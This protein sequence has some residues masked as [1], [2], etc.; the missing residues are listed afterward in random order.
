MDWAAEGLLDGL[1]G[2][3]RAERVE[4]LDWLEELGFEPDQ[5]RQA[6]DEGLLLLLPADRVV[7]GPGR[8]TAEEVGERANVHPDF[9]RLLRRVNGLAV[10]EP[11][12]ASYS[13]VDVQ[14]ADVARQYTDLGIDAEQLLGSARAVGRALSGLAGSLRALV[15]ELVVKPG[16]SEVELAR[17]YAERVEVLLPLLGPML[18]SGLRA[19][20][21]QAVRTELI[22]AAERAAGSL[23]GER[24]VAVAFADIVGFTKL[25]EEVDTAQLERVAARLEARTRD[26]ISPPVSLVKTIGD[27]VLLVSPDAAALLAVC[28]Q[29]SEAAGERAEEAE[30][31]E[32][33][34]QLR[35]GM[36]Y[37]PA[38]SRGGDW[39]GRA[40][41]LASRVAAAARPGSVL[42]VQAARDAAGEDVAHFSSAGSKHFKGVQGA[43]RLHRAR[44]L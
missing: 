5:I 39:Y 36:S 8:F 6:S 32:L 30:G 9:L 1:D 23:P 12:M 42:L 15:F 44:P 17:A 33:V 14:L 7:A 40:V 37:G 26:L 10:P 22:D 13:D 38:L 20:L 4:L 31:E 16:M 27:A 29:L 18:E 41:N 35:I 25:G 11:G 19:Q 34:P 43:V 24:E 2:D 21:R 28:L 3:A